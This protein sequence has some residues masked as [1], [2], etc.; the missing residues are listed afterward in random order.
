MKQGNRAQKPGASTPRHPDPAAPR[1]TISQ[2]KNNLSALLDRVRN[3]ESITIVDRD[4]PVARLVPIAWADDDLTEGLPALERS[5]LVRRAAASPLALA[6]AW[7]PVRS[8]SGADI[9][10]ALLA[11]RREDWR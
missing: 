9:L 11:E 8:A 5:G 4:R 10:G 1:A 6:G 3:G 7:E 2:T